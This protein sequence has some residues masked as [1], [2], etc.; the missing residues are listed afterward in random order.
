MITK[1]GE[2]DLLKKK[3]RRILIFLRLPLSLYDSWPIKVAVQHLKFFSTL[4][5][6]EM[7]LLSLNELYMSDYHCF[8]LLFCPLIKLLMERIKNFI[9][10]LE[11][12][13]NTHF[14]FNFL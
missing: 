11:K 6:K 14:L 4:K 8:N 3:K 13:E 10:E 12:K 7:Q 5:C 2:T 9:G 1:R